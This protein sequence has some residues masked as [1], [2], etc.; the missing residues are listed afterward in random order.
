M[1][2]C[3]PIEAC[4][5][6][7]VK[8]A[9][10]HQRFQRQ[11]RGRVCQ[12]G[13]PVAW[14]DCRLAPMCPGFWRRC[15][16]LASVTLD[17]LWLVSRC[18]SNSRTTADQI[19]KVCGSFGALAPSSEKQMSGFGFAKAVN[20]RDFETLGILLLSPATQMTAG[21][22]DRPGRARCGRSTMRNDEP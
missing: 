11:V 18:Q 19:A 8:V 22:R 16:V 15:T 7:N 3:C 17:A 13:Q 20:L 14:K 21:C 4:R 6:R 1:A 12:D 9:V 10:D 2:R 5:I